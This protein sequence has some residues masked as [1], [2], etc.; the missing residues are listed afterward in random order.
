MENGVFVL[1]LHRFLVVVTPTGRRRITTP[2]LKLFATEIVTVVSKT[3]IESMAI[4]GWKI[5]VRC[6][7]T[8]PKFVT[9]VIVVFVIRKSVVTARRNVTIVAP[10]NS[11]VLTLP[12]IVW[13]ALGLTLQLIGRRT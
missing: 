13:L 4:V 10:R 3:M 8:S 12:R 2:E 5:L 6:C 7:P 11:M 1:A 9:V